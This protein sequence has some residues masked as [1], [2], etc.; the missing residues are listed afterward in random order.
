VVRADEVRTERDR[1]VGGVEWSR[2]TSAPAVVVEH[3][4]QQ[5]ARQ[6]ERVDL[7]TPLAHVA[8]KT[9]ELR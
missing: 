7:K 2:I 5:G 8:I 4:A 9:V 3:F 6:L 1:G